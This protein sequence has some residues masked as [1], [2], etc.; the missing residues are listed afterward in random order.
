M[1]KPLYFRRLFVVL[2]LQ[3]FLFG[4]SKPPTEEMIK[5]EKALE[6]AK[7]KEADIYAQDVYNKTEKTYKKAKE[8][9]SAKSYKEAGAVAK[10][11][12]L[13]AQQAIALSESNRQTLKTE[14]ERIIEDVQMKIDAMKSIAPKLFKR[15]DAQRRKQL[16]EMIQKWEADLAEV[17]NQLKTQKIKQAFDKLKVLLDEINEKGKKDIITQINW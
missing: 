2:I 16:Q 5:A 9:V 12:P 6:Q 8:L 3:V 14:S 17:K 13:F 10:E 11:V 7:Q 4:C 15:K 1:L